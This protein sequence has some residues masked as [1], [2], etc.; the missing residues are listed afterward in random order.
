M[1]ISDSPTPALQDDDAKDDEPYGVDAGK[2][3]S[4]VMNLGCRN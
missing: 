4:V 3:G 1:N 2:F